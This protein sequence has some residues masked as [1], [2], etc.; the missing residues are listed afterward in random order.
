M[1]AY[2][3]YTSVIPRTGAVRTSI[4]ITAQYN[5][6][7]LLL[8]IYLFFSLTG[9]LSVALDLSDGPI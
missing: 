6:L 3:C 4:G 1:C 7:T 2:D 5:L 8:R 9:P